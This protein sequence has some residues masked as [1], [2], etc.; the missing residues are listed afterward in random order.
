MPE[1]LEALS[2]E[3]YERAES[4]AQ[5]ELEDH[6]DSPWGHQLMAES[7]AAQ[8]AH[9]QGL[10]HAERADESDAFP[11]RAPR[12]LGDIHRALQNPVDAAEAYHRARQADSSS[13]DDDEFTAVLED[14]IQHAATRGNHRARWQV[15]N[16]LADV[17][18]D[19][20]DAEPADIASARRTWAVELRRN[21]DYLEAVDILEDALEDDPRYLRSEALDLGATYAR[22]EMP[23]DALR[24]WE[25]YLDDDVDDD[26]AIQRHLDVA[27]HAG[28]HNLN[29]IA[30]DTL[31]QLPSDIGTPARRDEA[32]LELIRYQLRAD[33]SPEARRSIDDYLEAATDGADD[34]RASP[35]PY[36]R[37][38]DIADELNRTRLQITLLERAAQEAE[39]NREISARLAT[40]YAR[41]AQLDGVEETLQLFVERSE[42]STEAR[43]FAGNWAA[44]R[45][46]YQVA[47]DFL[48]RT[49]DDDAADPDAWRELAEVQGELEDFDAMARNLDTYVER[50]DATEDALS[51]A[52]SSLMDY[53]RYE[54]AERLLRR[55]QQRA[56]GSRAATRQLAEL[57]D[58]WSRPDDAAAVWQEWIDARGN[59]PEDISSVAHLRVRS[60][61]LRRGAELFERAAEYGEYERWI[62]AAELHDRQEDPTAVVRTVERFLDDHPDRPEALL[63]A[64]SLWDRADMESRQMETLTELIEIAP[65]DWQ[66]ERLQSHYTDLAR[67]LIDDGQHAA[68]VDYLTQ[69]VD[70]AAVTVD[71]L[72]HI[73]SRLS[74]AQRSP[75]LL[76]FFLSYED[77]DAARPEILRI[78]GDTYRRMA[79]DDGD[80]AGADD[81]SFRRAQSY[82]LEY[83]DESDI[84]DR[85][86]RTL[87]SEWSRHELWRPTARAYERDA[88][89]RGS[90]G[91]HALA[92]GR[93]LLELGDFDDAIQLLDKHL[94]SQRRNPEVAGQIADLLSD[95]AL[96]DRAREYAANLFLSGDA[97]NIDQGFRLLAEIHIQREDYD[98]FQRLATD[99]VERASNTTRARR[100]VTTLLADAGQWAAAIDHL[101]E[102]DRSPLHQFALEKGF[103]LYRIGDAEAA[104]GT[105]MDAAE[106]SSEPA[107]TFEEAGQ[108][109]E[110]R[111]E[112]GAANDAYR[113]AVEVDPDA[114][115]PRTA[116]GSLA[117]RRGD[118]ETGQEDYAI[119]RQSRTSFRGSQR[120]QFFDAYAST[121]HVDRARQVAADVEDD[122]VT[123]PGDLRRRLGTWELRSPQRDDQ[124]RGYEHISA[125]SWGQFQAL[126]S[127]DDAGHHDLVLELIEEEFADGDVT[128]AGVLLLNRTTSLSRLVDWTY[129]REL[130]GPVV[131]PIQ[132]GDGRLLGPIGDHRVRLGD[133]D[134]ALLYLR[135]ALDEGHDEY[136]LQYANTHLLLG[137]TQQALEQ[138]ERSFLAD[139]PQRE[140]LESILL[141]FELADQPE[142]ASRLLARLVDHPT[143]ID[144]A[145]PAKI[146][147]DLERHGNPHRAIDDIEQH[148]ESLRAFSDTAFYSD[149]SRGD[150]RRMT[151]GDMVH[152]AALNSLNAVATAG[153]TDAVAGELERFDDIDDSQLDELRLRIALA[154]GDS[155]GFD[156]LADQRVERADSQIRRQQHRVEL[157]RRAISAG[158]DESARQLVDHA[159]DEQKDF[160]SHQPM[161]LD[162]S[163]RIIAEDDLDGPID[164]YL[165]RVP[166]RRDARTTLSRELHRMGRD[167]EALRLLRPDIES[168]PTTD[169]LKQ[170]LAVALDDGDR[171]FAIDVTE[172]IMNTAED[173]VEVISDIIGSDRQGLEPRLLMPIVERIRSVVP[174]DINWMLNEARIHFIE[175][176]V[177]TGRNL[178]D[179]ALVAGDFHRDVV[180]DVVDMLYSER[181]MVEISRVVGDEI[182]DDALW[183]GLVVRMA[184]ADF[185]L[186]FD[187]H[188]RHWLERL[189]EV[190]DRPD[191]WRLELAD[192]LVRHQLYDAIEPTLS[193]LPSEPQQ[194]PFVDYLVGVAELATGDADRGVESLRRA[195]DRGVNR[196]QTHHA[197]IRA[198]LYGGH[199]DIAS[200][201]VGDMA[202]L[203]VRDDE[204]VSLPLELLMRSAAD[205]PEGPA[206]VRQ[207]LE[208]SVPRIVDGSGTTWGGFIG[209]L[210]STFED[211]GDPHG[212]YGFYR[213][214]LWRSQVANDRSA[215]PTYLNNLAYSYATTDAHIDKGLSKIRRAIVLSDERMPSFIDSLGWLMYR[216]GDLEGA[217][218]EI[219]RALRS[220]RGPLSGLHE[221]LRH[222]QV[223]TY[224]RG[225]YGE[226]A[227]VATRIDRLPPRGVEW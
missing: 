162:L 105:V 28:R 210:A 100:T 45:S 19:H 37:V 178:V 117:I 64:V 122:G 217:H 136:R 36:Q 83:L 94:Q 42:S 132:R 126:P 226:S 121:G 34:G 22:L 102:F 209:H 138:F 208:T 149:M 216:D 163:L 91:R 33:R 9:R 189:P 74:D 39:P 66:E 144:V 57:Y 79:S 190:T 206:A 108:F 119:A 157:A 139:P 110:A 15:I 54:E 85:N 131:D 56:P 24:A 4:I 218:R 115:G 95:F 35:I 220:Y 99:Y 73:A 63:E 2:A 43:R 60:G 221:L 152:R 183:P 62:D 46:N 212:A 169:T 111:G 20:P 143:H 14:A 213:D 71:A 146:R 170:G 203:P 128:T 188:A 129:Q 12:V 198:A 53:R 90:T 215:L 168:R 87:A 49:V 31:Q 26:E 161:I 133:L 3:D 175:G 27:D 55:L 148:L 156:T 153:F 160:R 159:L 44:D 69:F 191:I 89:R 227:D 51:T 38:I 113:R 13:V 155:A 48:E 135:A 97:S 116:R 179:D 92:H 114:P 180:T 93:A 88:E 125:Q 78:I 142:E 8:D 174:G 181:L 192:H 167:G 10:E 176:D 98:E 127:L 222:Q 219:S 201:F 86:W 68:A 130:L 25:H 177:E 134:G 158:L 52:A 200:A 187:D 11:V 70:S 17:A 123:P 207:G 81:P 204:F 72:E 140:R 61:D 195:N 224:E 172:R 67:L 96:Y 30:A 199:R 18:P 16:W 41:R 58:Q 23:D 147:D 109:L 29:D 154:E 184:E 137:N 118:L 21:G 120:Q 173:P 112:F 193:G 84:D 47:R 182:P 6:P 75:V 150:S 76:D 106:E 225:R 77:R 7:L 197:G 50:R 32:L 1:G 82:Y 101:E 40:I 145:L 166:N 103:H 124:R 59:Q 107:A 186:G 223:I 185:A 141:R 80:T 196:L 194:A 164:D 5:D 165:E 202:Q 104:W 211:T 151:R 214:H 205:L 65:E 171:D